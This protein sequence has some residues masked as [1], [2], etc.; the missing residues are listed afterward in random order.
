MVHFCVKVVKKG[1]LG[2]SPE[3]LKANPILGF[4]D[5]QGGFELRGKSL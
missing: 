1:K 3:G 4:K 2:W 5:L